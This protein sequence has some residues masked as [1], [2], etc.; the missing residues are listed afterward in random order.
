MSKEGVAVA[1]DPESDKVITEK[2]EGETEDAQTVLTIPAGAVS[3]ATDVTL[4]PY[5]GSCCNRCDSGQQGR[6]DSHD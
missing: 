2:G 4:T 1:V 5:L 6:S 3:T